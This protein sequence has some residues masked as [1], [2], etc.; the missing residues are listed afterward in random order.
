MKKGIVFLLVFVLSVFLAACGKAA[1]QMPTESVNTTTAV[2]EESVMEVEP[3]ENAVDLC[4]FVKDCLGEP[5]SFQI[6]GISYMENQGHHCYYLDFS[7]MVKSK[8]TERTYYYAEFDG[9]ELLCIVNENSAIHYQ[10]EGDYREKYSTLSAI[11]RE[12]SGLMLDAE[13]ISLQLT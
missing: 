12:E 7:H 11:F 3:L 5:D 1:D 10:T 13:W 4:Q 9:S 6:Y 2:S 8:E